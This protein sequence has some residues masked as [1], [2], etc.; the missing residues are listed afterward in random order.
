ML[1]K[2]MGLVERWALLKKH[3]HLTPDVLFMERIDV[4][5]PAV[6]VLG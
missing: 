2:A 4:H 3:Q 6:G 5:G 1:R